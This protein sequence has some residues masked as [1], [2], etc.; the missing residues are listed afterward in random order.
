MA[1]TSILRLPE[2]SLLHAQFLV[3][4]VVIIR[5]YDLLDTFK[6]FKILPFVFYR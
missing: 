2:H 1:N 3:L 5:A 6:P 4:Y